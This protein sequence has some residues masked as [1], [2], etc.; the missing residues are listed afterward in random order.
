MMGMV[1][2]GGMV[3]GVWFMMGMV[4]DEYNT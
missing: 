2:D 4:H 1:H 3:Y